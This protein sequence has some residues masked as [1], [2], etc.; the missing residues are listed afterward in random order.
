LTIEEW[1]NS[2]KAND[3]RRACMERTEWARPSED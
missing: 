3:A 1:E 2:V